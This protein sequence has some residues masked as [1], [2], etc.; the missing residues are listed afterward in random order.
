MNFSIYEVAR[1]HTGTV[2]ANVY[3]IAL[4]FTILN[5]V[6]F[7]QLSGSSQLE[8]T[9]NCTTFQGHQHAEWF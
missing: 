3:F 8:E 4:V 6:Q 9:E 1:V 2:Q 5:Q 7:Q